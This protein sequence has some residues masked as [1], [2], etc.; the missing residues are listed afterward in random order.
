MLDLDGPGKS[1]TWS[2]TV[3][4]PKTDY[5]MNNSPRSG[6]KS[7]SPYKAPRRE[8]NRSRRKP[9]SC[10]AVSGSL[11]SWSTQYETLLPFPISFLSLPFLSSSF[12][13]SFLLSFS[14]LSSLSLFLSS[15]SLFLSFLSLFLSCSPLLLQTS[16]FIHACILTHGLPCVTQHT[17]PCISEF[18]EISLGN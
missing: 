8:M 17:L 1:Y 4:Q 12:F 5:T 16:P 11:S 14:L 7:L 18:N 3:P 10:S 6:A 13:F 9:T 15:I 2:M